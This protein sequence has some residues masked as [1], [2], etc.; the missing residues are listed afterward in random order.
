MKSVSNFIILS[1]AALALIAGCG[2]GD[3]NSSDKEETLTIAVI[4]K[5][6]THEHWKSVHLGAQKAAAELGVEIIWKGP[7]KEDDREEQLQIYETFI[8]RQVDA[9]AI[10]PI[11]DRVFVRP[12]REASERFKLEMIPTVMVRSRPNGLPIA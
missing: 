11:D 1:I 10:A 4:P 12:V 2:G 9:I 8:A 7:L 3:E 6:A 5:G